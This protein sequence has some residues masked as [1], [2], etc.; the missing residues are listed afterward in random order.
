MASFIDS[1]GIVA[2][3]IALV[4]YQ[5]I[6]HL[7]N[8]QYGALSASLTFAVAAGALSGGRL[9]DH[10]GRKHV[11]SVTMLVS[12]CGSAMLVFNSGFWVLLAGMILMGLGTG[13]D[14][15]VSL[16]TISE[17]AEEK[18]RGKLIGLSNVL[19]LCGIIGAGICGSIVGNDGHTGGQILFA[20]VGVVALIVFLLR[21]GIPESTSWIAAQNERAEG[22][23]TVRA[24]R[25]T[26][27]DLLVKP[28]M[29]PFI[30]LIFFYALVNIGANT[31]GQFGTWVNVHVIHMSVAFSS[32][33]SVCMY[34]VNLLFYVAFMA[35]IDTKR[36]MPF[37]YLGAACYAGA[38]LIY[39]IGGFSIPTYI[40]FTTM[41]N[42]GSAFAFEGIMKVWTQES[43]PTLLRATAQ[44]SIVGTAR[45]CAGVAGLF[46]AS[47]V[48]LSPVGAY[49]GLFA[50]VCVGYCFAIWGF[51]GAHRNIFAVEGKVES[52]RS[53]AADDKESI[54]SPQSSVQV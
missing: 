19:W 24:S 10:F 34:P 21:L 33:L 1:C 28:Y 54:S 40:A 52:T 22:V 2:S 51:R 26:I 5:S 35:V 44:G 48:A 31:S 49:A 30:A 17:A 18:K 7:S 37:F 46:T 15:P 4:I 47:L 32:L 36:R 11:F 20:M 23:A 42:F 3:G 29:K 39:V 27:K 9:G 50:L 25:G 45:V 38:F 16:A 12:A 8:E 41:F 14:L 13:A 53:E 6:F 43:F